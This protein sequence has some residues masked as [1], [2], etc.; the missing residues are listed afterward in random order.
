MGVRDIQRT[1][2]LLGFNEQII[3][4]ALAAGE[5]DIQV[6]RPYAQTKYSALE[7]LA[8][9]NTEDVT[10]WPNVYMAKYY[11]ADTMIGY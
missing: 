10:D 3:L 2:Y 7:G 9:L 11:G 1:H 4:D 8:Y 5:K 6:P